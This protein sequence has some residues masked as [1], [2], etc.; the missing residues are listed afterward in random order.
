MERIP[1]Q[2]A[3]FR[4]LRHRR[5]LRAEVAQLLFV[6]A[7]VTLGLA[8][9]SV[10]AGPTVPADEVKTLLFSLSAGVIAFI[11]IVF[12]LL[13]LVVQF[14]STTLTPR[15]N[16]FRDD[17]LVW[18]AFGYFMGV[19][20]GCATAG[21]AIGGDNTVSIFV[22]I[23]AM[24]A[25]LAALVIFRALQFAAFRS[26]QLATTLFDIVEHG[27][28]VIDAL[29]D[30]PYEEQDC[31]PPTLPA[32]TAELR[33]PNRSAVLQGIDL[34]ALVSA[35]ERSGSVIEL[36]VAVGDILRENG[37]IATICGS[38]NAHDDETV[39]HCLTGGRERT[40]DQDPRFAFRLLVDIALR[41]LSSS[42]NDQATAV[43]VID[44]IDSI[45]GQLVTRQ[46]DVGAVTGPDGALRVVLV[47]PSWDQYLALAVDEITRSAENV[48][49]VLERLDRLMQDLATDAPVHRQAALEQRRRSLALPSSHR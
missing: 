38:E 15:L 28:A 35:A 21:L 4:A 26:I 19:F 46:L 11:S 25:V 36:T 33:W 3:I 27:R 18:R 45:L 30:E 5:R 16:L 37:V 29:Y 39:L 10:S 31:S 49:T 41:A 34:P 2:R 9:P 1:G 47:L 8:A 6:V 40:F 42:T 17:P 23:L 22:P 48:P 43:Q 24:V 44:A 13:F 14:G 32:V 7:G 20:A 12:S